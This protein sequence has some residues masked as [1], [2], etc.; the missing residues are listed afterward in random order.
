MRDLVEIVGLKQTLQKWG[1]D[2]NQNFEDIFSDLYDMEEIEKLEWI[3]QVIDAYFYRLEIPDEPTLYD[4]LILSL[5]DTDIIA[6]CNWDPLLIQACIRNKNAGLT[7]PKVLYLH[8]NVGVGYCEQDKLY[9]LTKPACPKCKKAY[10]NTPL[11]YPIKKKNYGNPFIKKQWKSLQLGLRHTFMLTV[12]GYSAPTTDTAALDLMKTAWDDNKIRNLEETVFIVDPTQKD[13]RVKNSWK[14]FVHSHHYEIKHDFY[15]SFL[16]NHPRRTGDA[17]Y[18][19]FL[20]AKFISDNPIPRNIGFPELW[21]W[22]SRFRK[23]ENNA[24]KNQGED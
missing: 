5:R 12:F 21:R 13:E 22:F 14:P 24:K 19:Q 11:L 1:I 3:K 17:F 15:E 18:N 2:H 9:G 20:M 23:A 6:T 4:H 7:M 10:K 8:G 16:A